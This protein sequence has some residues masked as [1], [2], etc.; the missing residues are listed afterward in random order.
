MYVFYKIIF[1]NYL[2]TS[3]KVQTSSFL[4]HGRKEMSIFYGHF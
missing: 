1:K 3:K 4:S 2:K